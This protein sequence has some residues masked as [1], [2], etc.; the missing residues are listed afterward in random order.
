MS[1]IA[2]CIGLIS[3]CSI[4]AC[5]GPGSIETHRGKLGEPLTGAG[6][7]TTMDLPVGMGTE[8]GNIELLT[9]GRVLAS[10]S[11]WSSSWWVLT[12]N[13]ATGSYA[14]G[15][16]TELASTSI[17]GRHV[18][19]SSILKDGRYW[20]AGGEY[21][22]N[23]AVHKSNRN[24][25]EVFDPVTE[26]WSALP[27]DPFSGGLEDAPTT[28]LAD[29]VRILAGPTR[30]D[31][32]IQIF[33]SVSSTWSVAA[34]APSGQ[35]CEG[36]S[37]LLRD[38]RVLSGS[39]SFSIYQPEDNTWV[40]TQDTTPAANA[41]AVGGELGAML[42][43]L[44][45]RVLVLGANEHNGLYF[46]DG[47]SW[48]MAADTPEGLGH[49]D[50]A[51]AVEPSGRVLAASTDSTDGT[52]ST[53]LYEYSPSDDAWVSVPPTPGLGYSGNVRMLALP[54]PN[55]PAGIGQIM[56]TGGGGKAWFYT[57]STLAA[58]GY[59]PAVSSVW[60]A[61]GSFHVMGTQLNGLTTG[62]DI[63]DDGK[64]ST[65]YPIAWLENITDPFHPSQAPYFV[66][67]FDFDQ[68]APRA[69]T[70]GSF[71]FTIPEPY[72]GWANG[73]W[74]LHVAAN[75]LEAADSLDFAVTGDRG[76]GLLPVVLTN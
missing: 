57:P 28:L 48:T 9:D 15:S 68:M 64:M 54:S 75:G 65:N 44:N 10:G 25:A 27:N 5:T 66:R 34:N 43:L 56:V 36:G 55:Q 21:T 52:G 24:Q 31:G 58:L 67:T 16:W 26:T 53:T 18:N 74:Q 13:P 42:M 47:D 23:G 49:S 2:H 35:S 1:K 76:W 62:A 40:R 72:S 22:A 6:T 37:I 59:R 33:D 8:P 61:F 73:S 12:P 39:S 14:T 46:P 32:H 38:G 17:L 29:G 50:T 3:C 19:P 60:T 30:Y 20:E 11:Q 69:D 70:V 71:S 41:F 63:G 7:F 4:T 51:A 45:G